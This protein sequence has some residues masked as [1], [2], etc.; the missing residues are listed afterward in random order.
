MTAARPDVVTELASAF[1]ELGKIIF[2]QQPLSD[3][4]MRTVQLTKT[5]LPVPAQ[6]SVTL[7]AGDEATTPAATD[8]LALKLDETQYATG[9]GPCLAA[10]QAGHVI[11]LGDTADDNRWPDFARDAQQHSVCSSLSVPLPVQRQV[12]GALNMYALERFRP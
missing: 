10:A 1:S 8:P 4:L 5:F 6:V 2:E 11:A 3:V 7:I 12:I 9:Y